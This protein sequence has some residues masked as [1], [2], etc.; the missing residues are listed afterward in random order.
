MNFL[1]F[2]SVGFLSLKYVVPEYC[3]CTTVECPSQGENNIVMGGGNANISYNYVKHG[4]YLVVDSVDGV[5]TPGS[6]DNGSGTT[7]CTE[8]YSRLL[9]DD[10]LNNCDAGHILA[11]RLGGYGNEPLNIFPQDPSINRGIYSQMEGDI[12]NC[13]GKANEGY[14]SWKFIYSNET[15]TKPINVVYSARFDVGCDDMTVT[16]SN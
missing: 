7:S 16:F 9:E 1:L 8:K 6:L 10:G 14:L 12:Y 15:S 11:N 5:I 3:V 13:M 4:E 2:L